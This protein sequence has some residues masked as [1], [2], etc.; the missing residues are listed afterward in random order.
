[1]TL[2]DGSWAVRAR[3]LLVALL[4][5]GG[6]WLT[7]RSLV[8][9]TLG[10]RLDHRAMVES[11]EAAPPEVSR[12]QH[13]LSVVSVP[14]IALSLGV[15]AAVALKRSRPDLAVAAAVTVV[16]ANLTTQAL[17]M[18]LER[19]NV[20]LGSNNSFPSGHMTVVTSLAV[21]AVLV[22]PRRLQP[23]VA[24]LGLVAAGATAMGAVALGW[25]RPSDIA[26]AGLVVVGWAAAAGAL[27]PG[28]RAAAA[29]PSRHT[30]VV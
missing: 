2:L 12:L 18:F 17:K 7:Y 1:M 9:S 10:Q 8:G 6:V 24:G 28:R 19:P 13:V 22:S 3:L 20:G 30:V 27:L 11:I 21:A 16:G 26:G 4:S 23:V 15:F 5:A 14:S 25:H 29:R